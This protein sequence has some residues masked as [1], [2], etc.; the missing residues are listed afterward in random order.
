MCVQI[1]AVF[2]VQ[3]S[4][5]HQFN[6]FQLFPVEF[7]FFSIRLYSIR[8][9]RGRKDRT[10]NKGKGGEERKCALSTTIFRQVELNIKFAKLSQ[11]PILRSILQHNVN[12]LFIHT[13]AVR[14]NIILHNVMVVLYTKQRSFIVSHNLKSI[15]YKL[16]R[17][18]NGYLFKFKSHT[19]VNK[20]RNKQ[21]I[22]HKRKTT[23]ST[24]LLIISF[25]YA[26]CVVFKHHVRCI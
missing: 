11:Y 21:T 9:E 23:I 4:V 19:H 24:A 5:K 26:Y 10:R 8:K 25:I 2:V 12:R 18:H 20:E 15:I 22:I 14:Q 3:N 1:W 6:F 13:I 16:H 7:L 17:N